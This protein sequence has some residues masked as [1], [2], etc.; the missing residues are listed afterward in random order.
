MR[1]YEVQFLMHFPSGETQ[2]V[3]V[4][5]NIEVDDIIRNIGLDKNEIIV[6]KAI[7]EYLSENEDVGQKVGTT[8]IIDLAE[9]PYLH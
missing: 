7:G 3:N 8:K 1:K 4:Q 6:T 2:N 5:V 9:S